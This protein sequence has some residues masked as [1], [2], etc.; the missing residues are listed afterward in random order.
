MCESLN[1]VRALTE[2]LT[3]APDLKTFETLRTPGYTEH[4][5]TNGTMKSHTIH[6][7]DEVAICRTYLKKGNTMENHQHP[8]SVE[9]IIVISGEITVVTPT[10]IHNLKP[11]QYVKLEKGITHYVHA[12]RDA[13]C[14]AITIPRDDGFPE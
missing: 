7:A 4:R 9:L 14:M 12:V 8:G 10:S 5:V 2:Q 11:E 6:T 13:C 1:K 3:G